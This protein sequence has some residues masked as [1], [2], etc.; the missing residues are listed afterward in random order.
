MSEIKISELV[1]GENVKD[2]D[3][4]M[5]VQNKVNKKITKKVFLSELIEKIQGTVL[6]ENEEGTKDSFTLSEDSNNYKY[7][8][9]IYKVAELYKSTKVKCGTEKQILLDGIN[10]TND[11]MYLYTTMVNL[12]G[13]SLNV[14]RYE[15]FSIKNSASWQPYASPANNV[16]ITQ[17]IGYK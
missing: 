15:T 3:L 9:I 11:T 6:Y 13:K 5:I 7:I 17:V 16:S 1:E 10:F 12:S 2:E 8:E 14:S 4:I